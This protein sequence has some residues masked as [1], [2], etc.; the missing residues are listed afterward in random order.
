MRIRKDL[1][2]RRMRLVRPSQ[3]PQLHN[4]KRPQQQEQS[5]EQSD[6]R[7]NRREETHRY[8]GIKWRNIKIAGFHPAQKEG[9]HA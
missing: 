5:L 4:S 9:S 6:Q 2:L 3:G 7:N 1:H 8:K